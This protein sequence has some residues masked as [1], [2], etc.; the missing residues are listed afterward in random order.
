MFNTILRVRGRGSSKGLD[1]YLILIYHG[2][3]DVQ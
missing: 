1:V 3:V 2:I